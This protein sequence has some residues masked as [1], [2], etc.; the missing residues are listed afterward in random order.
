MDFRVSPEP[1]VVR[2]NASTLNEGLGLGV[3]V[4][5]ESRSVWRTTPFSG[6]SLAVFFEGGSDPESGLGLVRRGVQ[7]QSSGVCGPSR[8]CVGDDVASVTDPSVRGPEPDRRAARRRVCPCPVRRDINTD[9]EVAALEHT[10]SVRY[11]HPGRVKGSR[12]PLCPSRGL[13]PQTRRSPTGRSRRPGF[14]LSASSPV[15]SE[16]LDLEV[17]IPEIT[18]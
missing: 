2:T 7:D 14:R 18:S 17:N 4:L 9:T 3:L 5:Q 11:V 1:R 13:D 12:H 16:R 6:R 15:P 8:L 10:G